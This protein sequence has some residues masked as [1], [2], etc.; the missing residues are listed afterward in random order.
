MRS[1]L[2]G[3]TA[4]NFLYHIISLHITTFDNVDGPLIPMAK[5]VEDPDAN[6]PSVF[7]SKDS[8]VALET[9]L[10]DPK[11]GETVVVTLES[12]E[13]PFADWPNM[14][15]S[16]CIT[17]SALCVLLSVVVL[18]RRREEAHLAAIAAPQNPRGKIIGKLNDIIGAAF[19]GR[20][21]KHLP[22]AA[23][24]GS[25]ARLSGYFAFMQGNTDPG[26]A[27]IACQTR[28]DHRCIIHYNNIAR[29]A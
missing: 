9:L 5:R 2:S 4:F 14:A 10:A 22:M 21:G 19:A 28:R 1:I 27:A 3:C 29:L 24:A 7:V 16:A 15:T 20:L 17:F 25:R 23:K 18:L 8:G 6:V 13:S 11:H 26:S 12:P